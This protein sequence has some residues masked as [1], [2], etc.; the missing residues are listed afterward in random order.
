LVKEF[1]KEKFAKLIIKEV[2]DLL[3]REQWNRGQ[4]WI[5]KDGDRI[6]ERVESHFGVEE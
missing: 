5:C 1:N 4:D 6:I 3:D 2:T